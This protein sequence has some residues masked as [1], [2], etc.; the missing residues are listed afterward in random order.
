VA[1]RR[2]PAA[3]R[4]TAGV[5]APVVALLSIDGD[6]RPRVSAAIPAGTPVR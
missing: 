5:C 1:T 3:A 2:S 4:V 6:D